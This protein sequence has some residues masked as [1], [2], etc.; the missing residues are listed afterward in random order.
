[1]TLRP[2]FK[3]GLNTHFVNF[4]RFGQSKSQSLQKEQVK[5]LFDF[6]DNTVELEFFWKDGN[7]AK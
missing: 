3:Q 4:S 7:S 2:V 1:M 5:N 6:V